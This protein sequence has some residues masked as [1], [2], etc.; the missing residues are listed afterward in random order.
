M[1]QKEKVKKKNVRNIVFGDFFISVSGVLIAFFLTLYLKEK[2]LSILEIG[3]LFTF[4][5]AIATLITSLFYSKILRKIKLKTGLYLSTLFVFLQTFIFYLIPTSTG[6]PISK[7]TGEIHKSTYKV[8][9]DTSLQHNAEENNKRKVI[10]SKLIS[11]S[12]GLLVGL[13]LSVILVKNFG[14]LNSFLIFSLISL[15][16]IFFFSKI[17]E[18][19]R[20]KLKT[21]IKL[22]KV[23]KKVRLLILAE[24]VYWFS[25]ASSFHLVTT[26]LVMDKFAGSMTWLAII[27]GG[28]Y[29]S[30]IATT[31]LTRRKLDKK[32][33]A[34]TSILGMGI[35]LLSAIAIIISNNLYFALGAFILEGIGAGIWVPSKTS[36]VWS[37]TQKENREKVSGYVKGT[38]GFVKAVGPLAGGAIAT[39]F[40]ILGPFYIKAILCIVVIGI[41]AYILRKN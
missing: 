9:S 18:E 20:F 33:S 24:M 19:T 31:I 28:L 34:K 17:K 5:L 27:F 26:F 36:L 1:T 29:V 41:Y 25:M 22:P 8:S 30:I 10:S 15:P 14:F 13:A 2:G 12:L 39:A 40:G 38:E 3:G 32:D 37:N 7:F 16:A 21:R 6:A 35:L 23:K 11:N 4:G